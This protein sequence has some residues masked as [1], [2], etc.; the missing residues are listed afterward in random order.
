MEPVVGAV[1]RHSAFY[2]DPQTGA[3]GPKYFVVLAAPPGNDLV[4]RLLTSRYS[5]LRPKDPPCFHGDPYP[6][7][8]LGA[9]GGPLGLATWLDLRPCDDM[10]RWDLARDVSSGLIEPTLQLDGAVLRAAMA[11]AAGSPDATIRQEKLIRDAL[12]ALTR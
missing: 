10:D 7:F 1:L 5:G 12:A 11:C 9:L 2:V 6:G 8:Y 4:I 3:F